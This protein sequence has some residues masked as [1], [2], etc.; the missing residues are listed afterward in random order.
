MIKGF[1]WA[2]KSLL[3]EIAPRTAYPLY[4]ILLTICNI[5]ICTLS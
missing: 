1:V 3:P 2:D 4:G 5:T